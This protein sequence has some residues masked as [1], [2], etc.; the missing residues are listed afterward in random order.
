MTSQV[1]VLRVAVGTNVQALGEAIARHFRVPAA[2]RPRAVDVEAVGNEAVARAMKGIAAARG[3]TVPQG[4]DLAVVPKFTVFE[5]GDE[6]VL[7][8]GMTLTVRVVVT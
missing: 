5:V 2:V 4:F 6:A 3:V 7:R 8:D 1:P